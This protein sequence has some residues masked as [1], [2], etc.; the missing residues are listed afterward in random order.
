MTAGHLRTELRVGEGIG[1]WRLGRLHE[2][3][4]DVAERPMQGRMDALF[5]LATERNFIPHE[6]PCRTE[7][8]ARYRDRQPRP[9][10][11]F[12]PQ[13]VWLP[14]GSPRLDLSGF[15]FRPTRVECWAETTLESPRAQAARV[16]FST[17][18][19]ALL[20]VD[21]VEV[22]ALSG[23]RRNFEESVEAVL[24][25]RAGRNTVTV[26]FADL[27][28]RDTR[29]YVA[30]ELIE[31]DG[32]AVAL[33]VAVED[34]RAAQIERLLGGMRFERPF[35]GGGEVAVLL[36]EAAARPLE[37]DIRVRGDFMSTETLLLQRRL[38]AGERRLVVGPAG[39]LPADFRHFDIVLRDGGFEAERVLTVEICHLER[40]PPAP[41][42]L[43]ERAAE[44]LAHVAEHGEEDTV[45]ALARLALGR[46]GA[47][48]DAMIELCLPAILDLHDCADFLLVPLLWC[49]TRW[50]E[51]MSPETR[52]R[53]DE[54]ILAFRYWMD[55]PGNDVMWYFSENHALLYHTA[56]YL[57]GTL[58]PDAVF[59][60]SG[61][62]GRAQAETG[63]KRLREWLD[64]FDAC[65]MA[66]WNSAPYFPIDLKGLCAL[67][68]LAPDA[69]IRERAAAAIRRLLEIVALSSHQGL[70]TASQGRSYEHTLR[71]GRSLELSAIA[72]LAFG[73]GWYGR[74]FHALPQLALCLTEHGLEFDRR[75]AG[76]ALFDGEGGLEWRFR[77]GENGFAALYHYKTRDHAMGSLAAYRWGEWGYQET[78]LHLRLGAR[79][80][81]Q[82]WINHPG[83]LIQSG[84]AR[85]S[86]WGGCGTLPRTHQYRALA[87]LDFDIREGQPDFT[88]AW[89]PSA[90]F[91][92]VAIAGDRILVRAGAALALIVGD[93]AFA[94][95]E[96][97]PMAGCEVCLPGRR[98]RW[99]VRLSDVAAE[100][101]LDAFA[102][103]F[104][105]LSCRAEDGALVVDDPDYGTVRCLADGTVAAEGRRLD[106]AGWSH[107]GELLEFPEGRRI[108]LP[109]HEERAGRQR[110]PA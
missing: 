37:A 9:A 54:A 88:H 20:F 70:I 99:L 91:D 66:E 25:L 80:E 22:A 45:R 69:D 51:R 92:E 93:R 26:W 11:A 18:G 100:G 98:G 12:E 72:R 61:R 76:L 6:Y 63:R 50:P 74:R 73:R 1:H 65:E 101:S 71:P 82:I 109:S 36:P 62:A 40:L 7:F 43:P 24:P 34:E 97:G 16:R 4:F 58:F 32:L 53:V 19:G 83:E 107:A 41:A 8:A 105:D 77:Q 96:A 68:A 104:G 75:L 81:A 102:A 33:P 78:V 13:R 59:R 103:R 56:C 64:H 48:T 67:Q 89:L 94:A 44:A 86:Y 17:C 87:L 31:G 55:E 47:D 28:E 85:P 30:V 15:W 90:E 27:C 42:T 106:P 29:Y 21:G 108:R 95:V 38:A 49:R 60:R 5:F 84:Y 52:A 2:E 39:E 3:R 57:A 46:G 10:T 35:Y 79:P 23:Y 14:F 110:I